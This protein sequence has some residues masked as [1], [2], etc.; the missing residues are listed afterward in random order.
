MG[1][2]KPRTYRTGPRYALNIHA[3]IMTK[4]GKKIALAADVVT[5]KE[6][7][8]IYQLRE[9]V[10]LTIHHPEYS[11]LNTIPMWGSGTVNVSNGEIRV[12]AYAA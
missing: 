1:E 10:T 12:K 5:S 7:S 4:D 6:G 3:E 9:N 2:E 8:P 11:W